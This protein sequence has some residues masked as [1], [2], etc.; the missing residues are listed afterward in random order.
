M[1]LSR[2]AFVIHDPAPFLTEGPATP[3]RW[4]SPEEPPDEPSKGENNV[5]AAAHKRRGV[6]K[7][8]PARKSPASRLEK[9]R[10]SAQELKRNHALM[11][12]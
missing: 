6:P 2:I 8:G 9:G 4:T 10:T 11:L 1:N 12:P 5:P 3:V 7:A